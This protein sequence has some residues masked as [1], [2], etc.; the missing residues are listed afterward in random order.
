MELFLYIALFAPIIGSLFA[1]MFANSPK[2]LFV[3]L[4]ASSL[5]AV[6]LIAMLGNRGI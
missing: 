3:G 1:A 6:S 5:L 2:K 4:V